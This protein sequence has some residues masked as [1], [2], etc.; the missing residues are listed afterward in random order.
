MS[1]DNSMNIFEDK[2]VRTLW[3]EI[4]NKFF[5]EYNNTRIVNSFLF[6][7]T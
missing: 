2:E 3:D 5:K 4:N 7:F 6:N 1:Q